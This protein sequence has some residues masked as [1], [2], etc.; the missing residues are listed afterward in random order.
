MRLGGKL[1]R[2][3]AGR[4][5]A[6]VQEERRRKTKLP[7]GCLPAIFPIQASCY[8]KQ[9]KY[10][11]AETLYKEILT[12]AHEKE[13]GSVNGESIVTMYL[14]FLQHRPTQPGVPRTML[15]LASHLA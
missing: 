12:R 9:G 8:L 5:R 13:F 11:D 4:E 1:E 7:A 14:Q 2:K 10:Q 15:G 3:E 6:D